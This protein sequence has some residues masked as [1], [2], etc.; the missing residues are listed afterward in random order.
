MAEQHGL[1]GESAHVRGILRALGPVFVC[2]VLFGA[3]MGGCLSGAHLE[4]WGTACTVAIVLTAVVG[5]HGVKRLHDFVL[6]ARGETRVAA[7]LAAS[8]SV[9]HVFNDY[10]AGL[11]CVDH[12]VLAT[13]GVYAVETK[14]WRAR[15]TA[16]EGHLLADGRLPSRSPVRQAVAQAAAVKA[17]LS[18]HGCAEMV[19][20][21]VCI[22]TD[23]YEGAPDAVPGVCVL[24]ARDLPAWIASRPV[25]WTAADIERAAG[26]M[27]LGA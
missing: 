21:V 12:V 17:E 4:I 24:N 5:R 14:A 1:P 13:S 6:G 22:A 19:T 25:A 2:C 9:A 10:R 23:T 15:V 11:R 8:P 3:T 20:P 7:E 16:E 26:M 18:S 27:G